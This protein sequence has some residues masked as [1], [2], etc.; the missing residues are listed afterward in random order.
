MAGERRI[1]V[2]RRLRQNALFH[3]V[4]SPLNRGVIFADIAASRSF[5]F[6]PMSI[7][8]KVKKTADVLLHQRPDHQSCTFS[9]FFGW[10]A[11]TV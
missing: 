4:C 2:A 5:C 11:H 1:A 9:F 6:Y 8:V 10:R 7:G 3:W